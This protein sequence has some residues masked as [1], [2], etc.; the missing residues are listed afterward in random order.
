MSHDQ[1][2]F[3]NS[4]RR[5]SD[6]IQDWEKQAKKDFEYASLRQWEKADKMRMA[7]QG[8]PALTFDRTRVIIESVA[9]SEITERYVSNYVSRD[10]EPGSL[11]RVASEGLSRVNRY[12]ASVGDYEQ[13]ESRAFWDAAVCG[14]GCL[15]QHVEYDEDPEGAMLN[16][17]VPVWEIAWDPDSTA[18]NM[19]DSSFIIRDKWIDE[20][21]LASMFGR[22]NVE[23][24]KELAAAQSQSGPGLWGNFWNRFNITVK[25]HRHA[26]D[27]R[28]PGEK[29]YDS[30]TGRV[31]AFEYQYRQRRYGTKIFTPDVDDM[32]ALMDAIQTG[33]PIPELEETVPREDARARMGELNE[34]VSSINYE[35]PEGTKPL[36]MPESIEDFPIMKYYRCWHTWHDLLSDPEEITT[37]GYTYE[38]ITGFE[39]WKEPGQ[40]H[41]FGLMRPMRDPQAYANKFLSHAV[42]M[43]ASNPKGAL[44]A[45]RGLFE[46]P[47]EAMSAW[48]SSTGVMW[49]EDGALQT[50][51]ERFRHL[52]TQAS[53][54]GAEGLM[55]H[56]LASIPESVGVSPYTTG[57]IGDLKRTAGSSIQ[58]IQDSA[59]KN[60]A[61]LFDSL[62]LYRKR[63]GRKMLHYVRE[64]MPE[65]RL[66]ALLGNE[67]ADLAPMVLDGSIDLQY[68]VKA[69]ERPTS[70]N[71]K[72]HIFRLLMESNFLPQM[73][74]QGTPV[75]PELAD[76]FPIPSDA[77]EQLK[78]AL[79]KTYD[80]QMNSLD[81]QNMQLQAQMMQMQQMQAQPPQPGMEGEVPQ[82]EPVPPEGAAPNP[83]EV[84]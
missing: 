51:K 48:A 64:Y 63:M 54:R 81:L 49:A 27:M 31:R 6:Y 58:S 74:S 65:E 15:E 47:D 21:E 36:D 43:W 7:D 68:E 13:N 10:P 32:P 60:Q 55:Q 52:T 78:E 57:T 80:L 25:D 82:E 67:A 35:L 17:R 62:R 72:Q 14:V 69:E 22:E 83:D 2:D 20:D 84:M 1:Q 61:N 29:F 19:T 4:F 33:G 50:Q 75:P 34:Q 30:H 37:K 26:Y 28:R 24:I 79:Q 42:H 23:T 70:A 41:W 11:G 66:R 16:T 44:M 77:A 18:P 73:V 3:K 8:M 39:D 9:G 59:M 76:F 71:E 5:S 40:R 53:M 38:F 46:D 56:A 45:E 12:V